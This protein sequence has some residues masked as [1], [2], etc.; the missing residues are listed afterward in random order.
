MT[1]YA[2]DPLLMRAGNRIHWHVYVCTYV[3]S[4][5]STQRMQHNAL[6]SRRYLC[7]P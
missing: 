6:P 2:Q 1:A 4:T 5:N 7:L 3:C